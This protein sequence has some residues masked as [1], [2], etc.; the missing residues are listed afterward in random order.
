MTKRVL[1]LAGVII[2][3]ALI[4]SLF[5]PANVSAEYADKVL[6]NYATKAGMRPVVFPHWTHRIRVRCKVCH[7]DLGFK[8]MLGSNDIKMVD[9]MQGRFCGACHNGKIAWPAIY[10]DRCH[11]GIPPKGGTIPA[12]DLSN[13]TPRE[14]KDYHVK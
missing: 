12:A 8:L 2:P 11:S 3:I 10:C 9:I 13:T 5:T 7:Q 4:A 6:N 1:I 14:T